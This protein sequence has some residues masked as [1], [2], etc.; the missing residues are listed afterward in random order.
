MA[1][2]PRL[3][4][5]PP[6]E[7][8]AF[9]LYL[10]VLFFA[11]LAFGTTEA[12]SIATVEFLVVLSTLLF[13]ISRLSQNVPLYS[14]T[15][16]LP[17]CLFLIWMYLQ[18]ISLPPQ[19][20]QFVSPHMF[21]VYQPIL[22]SQQTSYWIPLTV[23]RKATLME[24][25]RISSYAL[26]YILTVQLLSSTNRLKTTAHAVVALAISIAFLA[27]L[28]H[29]TSP[30]KIFWFRLVPSTP[31]GPWVYRNHYAGF[32]VM[33]CPLAL[34]LFSYYR[35]N[36]E[37]RTTLREKF[38]SLFSMPG[39]NV[40]LL[41]GFGTILILTSIVLSLSRGGFFSAF[42]AISLFFIFMARKKSQSTTFTIVLLCCGIL[43][44]VTQ[45]NWEQIFTKFEATFSQSEGRLLI[46]RDSLHIIY[47]FAITGTGAGT[48]V[49]IFPDYKSFTDI[50]VYEHAHNDYIELLTD[51]G[52]IGFTFFAWF[53]FKILKTGLQQIFSRHHYFSILISIGSFCGIT[54]L[55]IFSFVD[56]N[57]HNGANGLYFFFLC[58]L[59]ISVCHTR[60]HSHTRPN[61]LLR[62]SSQATGKTVILVFVFFFM[63]IL[64]RVQGGTILAGTLFNKVNNI[65]SAQIHPEKK[66]KQITSLLKQ[67]Q[68][69]DPLAG[70]YPYALGNIE[71]YGQHYQNALAH[72]LEAA[73]KEPM[74]GEFL[75]AAGLLLAKSA[76]DRAQELLETGYK[77]AKQKDIA[78]A[79]LFEFL[80]SRKKRNEALHILHNSLQ[81]SPGLLRTIYPLLI[82]SSFS[83]SE[84]ISVLPKQTSSWITFAQLAQSRKNHD[85]RDY[86]MEQAFNFVDQEPKIT[87]QL[88]MTVYYHY[89]NKKNE[90]KAMETLKKGIT[91]LPDYARFHLLLGDYY[92]KEKHPYEAKKEYEQ[93]LLIEPENKEANNKL[94]QLH[95]KRLE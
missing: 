87:P 45:F 73:L 21:T 61:L 63:L 23:N 20:V 71:K 86:F 72:Y 58:G 39:S 38:V 27:I 57:M 95:K 81:K 24:C 35:P 44:F 85:D 53:V 77:R 22:D 42:L 4:I 51:T 49:N 70:L 8:G 32:M 29:C 52:L 88:F 47:D 9:A 50:S 19:L 17:L 28:Q 25:M 1:T 79:L 83:R 5:P 84:I 13:F 90:D 68:T 12:W 69:F 74:E 10:L 66:I 75:Q 93:V 36:I 3:Q 26:F 64:L 37:E 43:F 14:V 91:F 16:I 54:G 7:Q 15:G 94:R 55:L 76:P 80:L 48:F 11:P 34:A 78:R 30:Q 41:L 56:F 59:L 31:W 92:L 33:I 89:H 18:C 60:Q 40:Q 82:N 62:I 67:A 2:R 46:W 6:M 65:A